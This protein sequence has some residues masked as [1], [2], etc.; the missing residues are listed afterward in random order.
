MGSFVRQWMLTKSSCFTTMAA[1]WDLSSTSLGNT[2]YLQNAERIHYPSSRQ[3]NSP[4]GDNVLSGV[5]LVVRMDDALRAALGQKE[6]TEVP[7]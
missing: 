3:E 4:S 6:R 2:A 5:E 1:R 7:K